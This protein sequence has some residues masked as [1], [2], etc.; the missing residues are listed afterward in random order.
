MPPRH[1]HGLAMAMALAM[2]G[3]GR[4]TIFGAH[5]VRPSAAPVRPLLGCWMCNHAGQRTQAVFNGSPASGF[6]LGQPRR[7]LRPGAPP[8][9]GLGGMALLLVLLQMVTGIL[10]MLVYEP[11]TARACV[12]RWWRLCKQSAGR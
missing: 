1:G 8:R 4:G 7:P 9:W 11:S 2:R 5:T 10:L 3:R 6:R 12:V